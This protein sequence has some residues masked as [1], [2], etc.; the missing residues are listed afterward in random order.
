MKR[1]GIIF[2]I[3]SPS[4]GGKTTIC[5]E[6]LKQ[7]PELGY[8]ISVTSRHPRSLEKEG[9]DYF[10]ISKAE[11]DEK[12][13]KGDFVEWAEVHGHHYGTP[14]SP[15]EETLHSGRDII[16]DIDVQ[17]ALQIKKEYKKS[18]L[19][20]L[21][22]PS[23]GTLASRLKERKTDNEKEIEKRLA[24]AQ[25]EMASLKEY[26]Y[27]VVNQELSRAVEE[28]KAIYMVAKL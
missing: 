26:D 9:K 20:F 16:L 3:S 19:I 1:K 14:R 2:V 5:R 25:E 8:S 15:L 13:K 10:F 6:L 18:C 17:G 28:V 21:L 11:F 7:L 4:G 23:L 24:K 27:V 12:I 22:P